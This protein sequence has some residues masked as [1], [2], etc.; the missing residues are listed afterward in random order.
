LGD[1]RE[2]ARFLRDT[3]VACGAAKL[4]KFHMILAALLPI[5]RTDIIAVAVVLVL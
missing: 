4:E 1:A 3:A 2:N 5:H